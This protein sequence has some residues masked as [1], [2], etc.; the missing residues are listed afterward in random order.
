[1]L[2]EQLSNI[3]VEDCSVL[4]W[5]A[6]RDRLSIAIEA[7]IWP[8]H[9]KYS[10]P[11]RNEWT[12]YLPATLLFTSVGQLKGLVSIT[13]VSPVPGSA[14]PDYGTLDD[15]EEKDGKFTV[16]GPFGNLSFTAQSAQLSFKKA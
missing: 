16:V 10:A 3:M 11:K 4:S 2:K 15:I 12:C 7:S 1:M 9:P 6:E 5:A 13:H 8:G 14:P